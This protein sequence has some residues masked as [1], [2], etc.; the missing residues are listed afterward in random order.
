MAWFSKADPTYCVNCGG[1]TSG[2]RLCRECNKVSDDDVYYCGECGDEFSR[3]E[4]KYVG[5]GGG[6]YICKD[7]YLEEGY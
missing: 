2:K 5:Y 7:C 3:N 4:V 1:E 6:G